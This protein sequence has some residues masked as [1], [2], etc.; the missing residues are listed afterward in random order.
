MKYILLATM[1]GAAAANPTCDTHTCTAGTNKGAGVECTTGTCD[2]ATCCDLTPQDGIVYIRSSGYEA[3][4]VEATGE[5]SPTCDQ[6]CAAFD[7]SM[8]GVSQNDCSLNEYTHTLPDGGQVGNQ[9]G[10]NSIASDPYGCIVVGNLWTWNNDGSALDSNR[11]NYCA[12]TTPPP[13]PTCDAGF[14]CDAGHS[15][16]ADLTQPCGQ[17]PCHNSDC[18]DADPVKCSSMYAGSCP[19]RA[20]MNDVECLASGCDVATCCATTNYLAQLKVMYQENKVS[21]GARLI[22][23]GCAAIGAANIPFDKVHFAS[24]N[25]PDKLFYGSHYTFP[26]EITALN[27]VIVDWKKNVDGNWVISLQIGE[28]VDDYEVCYQCSV[29]GQE[30]FM[31]VIYDTDITSDD[32]FCNI[33]S[34]G[35]TCTDRQCLPPPPE[36]TVNQNGDSCLNGGTVTGTSDPNDASPCECDCPTG[37]EGDRCETES[38]CTAH[39]D[40]NPCQNG[41]T[42]DGTI[43]SNNCACNCATGYDGDH[44]ENTV[45]CTTHQD[46]NACE[47][48]GVPS[49]SVA[50]GTCY[51]DCDATNYAPPY[52]KV[53]KTCQASDITCHNGGAPQGNLVAGCT[54]DCMG[55]W[56]G[57]DCTTKIPCTE[58]DITCQN[59]GTPAGNLVDGCTCACLPDYTGTN[60]ETIDLQPIDRATRKKC[61]SLDTHYCQRKGGTFL[62][63]KEHRLCPSTGCDATCCTGIQN[64]TCSS[65]PDLC[66]QRGFTNKTGDPDCGVFCTPK[67]CCEKPKKRGCKV[68]DFCNSDVNNDDLIHDGTL[69]FSCGAH[70]ACD[71]NNNKCDCDQGYGGVACDKKISAFARQSKLTDIRAADREGRKTLVKEY[72]KD[73][74]RAA[75]SAENADIKQILKDNAMAVVKED[76]PETMA[77][78]I[79]KMPR[80]TAMPDNENEEDECATTNAATCGMV[81]LA[82]DRTDNSQTILEAG[83]S[84]GSWTVVVDGTQ[85][86]SKQTKTG[87]SY[88]MQ[89]WED[90]AWGTPIN[91]A[92][93]ETFQCHGRVLFVGSQTGVCD[94]TT[95]Q[96]G[97]TCY[98]TGTD[99]GCVC[100]TLWRG[101]HCE[102]PN[103][104]GND[105]TSQSCED[106]IERVDKIAYQNL[107]CP[108][109]C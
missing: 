88:S 62:P 99:Y 98:S 3:A 23:Q 24:V 34:A 25:S 64:K 6:L 86:L 84:D 36:C 76:L 18:C 27:S 80:I 59:G 81:D 15:I 14:T 85:I 17:D 63:E 21:M 4:A 13:N 55:P 12:C 96:N 8:T 53:P 73:L 100:T 95:C 60:C 83:D 57:A 75:A 2:V 11:E 20:L 101:D 22:K 42:I 93:G 40:G 1:L 37:Y 108:C 7:S 43:P 69:C 56:T 29:T 89:C 78:V 38:D 45:Q 44:C 107:G 77:A 46:T 109:D 9:W 94:E 87:N 48:G 65:A 79:S 82:D 49:G 102:L 16:K 67:Q 26:P 61:G 90:D 35:N 66:T 104:S 92:T 68:A 58:N 31:K 52:C 50:D 105:G 74:V 47:N 103:D 91:K 33:V 70:G 39:Q 19:D 30:A 5:N 54:C 72:V 97:G 71:N 28:Y 32:E 106:A 41:A 51:C 10:T